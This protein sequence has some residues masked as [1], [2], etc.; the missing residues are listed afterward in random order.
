MKMNEYNENVK[1]F[2]LFKSYEIEQLNGV[3][4]V[5]LNEPVIDGSYD[6]KQCIKNNERLFFAYVEN[7]VFYI[8]RFLHVTKNHIVILATNNFKV[9]VNKMK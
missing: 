6:Y 4:C 7:G 2:G 9:E 8:G 5:K 3:T 1:T